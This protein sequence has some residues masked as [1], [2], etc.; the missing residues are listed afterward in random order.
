MRLKE[1]VAHYDPSL[2]AY[3]LCQQG[4]PAE[5]GSGTE[6][7]VLARLSDRDRLAALWM[8]LPA[9]GRWLVEELQQVGGSMQAL[10]L[11]ILY[12][13]TAE[14][15][16]TVPFEEIAVHL[17][18][19][20]LIYWH[21]KGLCVRSLQP[22]GEA[23]LPDEVAIALPLPQP[24]APDRVH[25]ASPQRLARDL[26]RMARFLRRS[27]GIALTRD[28]RLPARWVRALQRW[29]GLAGSPHDLPYIAF[30]RRLLERMGVLR[31]H[32]ATLILETL[33][34]FWEQEATDRAA[35]AFHAWKGAEISEGKGAD[36]LSP[37]ILKTRLEQGL[38]G[39]E[40]GAWIP[41]P[42]L[43]AAALH[44]P[45]A[46][47]PDPLSPAGQEQAARWKA[48]LIE[49][50]LWPLHWLGVLDRGDRAGRWTAVRLTSFGAWMLGIGEP[51]APPKENGRLVVQPDF[52]ILAFE[53]ISEAIRSALEAFTEP[54]PGEPI[55][56]YQITREALY[57]GLSQGWDIPRVIR[58]LEGISGDPLPPN[59]RRSLEDWHRRFNRV[60]IYRRVTLVRGGEDNL[61]AD[62]AVRPLR[63]GL[64]WTGERAEAL[65]ARWRAQGIR[66]WVSGFRPE[67]LRHQV[68]AE[69]SG[70]LRW[71]GAFPHPGVERLLEPFTE[72]VPEGF[73]ITE[74]SLRA[75]REAGL[76]LSEI[77]Q[78]LQQVH[79]GPLP[80]GLL[81]RLLTWSEHPPR[82]RW[83]PVI[84]L[85]MDRP[86][87]LEALCQE[88]ALSPWVR[89]LD[90]HTLMVRADHAPA[91]KAWLEAMG[92][93][94]EEVQ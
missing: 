69:D 28:G 24:F 22:Q 52:R 11:S 30:L 73:R 43:A 92:I 62:P 70:I 27:P 23:V 31:T 15:T 40:A 36:Y 16:P 65:A 34:P 7:Q 35:G 26:G 47:A 83:E 56:V 45:A 86:E 57:R 78:R 87:I 77:L 33:H 18:A 14:D 8:G 58:L 64:G 68:V 9:E 75:G 17:A 46:R 80:A 20:G 79:R 94:V 49:E 38:R 60:R 74:A 54:T 48:W 63:E 21:R 55:S 32:G 67:D 76:S 84:L 61:P 4:W 89:P 25:L 91:L 10:V 29:L 72:R 85:R 50:I 71:T 41:L 2:I 39:H 88:P 19:L 90:A 66:P 51:W 5:G 6:T 13:A 3:I 12:E 44:E 93:M 59:V 82:A 37:E 42:A 1:L 81:A 53:P